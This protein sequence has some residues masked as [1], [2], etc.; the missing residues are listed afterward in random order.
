[1]VRR[2]AVTAAPVSGMSLNSLTAGVRFLQHNRILLAAMTLDMFAVLLGGAV[3]LLPVFAEKILHV[4]AT[5]FGWMRAAPAVGALA[6]SL[7]LAHRPPV[8][9][10]GRDLLLAVAGFG[11]VTIA[12]GLSH[13]FVFSLVMLLLSGALDMISV[14]IRHTLVQLLTPD[15]MRGRVSA[16]NSMFIGASNEPGGFESGLVAYWAG[17]VFSVVSGGIGTL[18][19]VALVAWQF[20]RLRRYGRLD[21]AALEDPAEA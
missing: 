7:W 18:V 9:H 3:T 16:V 19:V 14:V 13:S 1:F 12:F 20:P 17:S 11:A 2:A 5:G 10:A 21:G 6:T 8:Q 15:S 4:G